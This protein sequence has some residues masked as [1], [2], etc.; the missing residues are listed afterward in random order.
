M[1]IKSPAIISFILLACCVF[2]EPVAT[3]YASFDNYD[4]VAKVLV[5]AVDSRTQCSYISRE[6]IHFEGFPLQVEVLEVL[7][8]DERVDLSN[9][10][11]PARST[12]NGI[13]YVNPDLSKGYYAPSNVIMLACSLYPLDRQW[14]VVDWVLTEET[15][16]QYRCQKAGIPVA[17]SNAC[18]DDE[19]E[20]VQEAIRKRQ[21]L[22]AQ[23]ESGKITWE[24]YQQLSAPYT[25]IINKPSSGVLY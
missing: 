10:L 17:P 1:T 3:P 11:V 13:H 9:L 12:V 15:W 8:K 19:W 24:E 18:A 5:R 25:A 23:E 4:Y 2:A 16:N 7:K 21:E 14:C 6:D 22:R 20:I